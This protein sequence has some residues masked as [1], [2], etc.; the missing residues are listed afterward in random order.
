MLVRHSNRHL[1]KPMIYIL[2]DVDTKYLV[3]FVDH[4]AYLI[5][6]SFVKL[7]RTLL[8]LQNMFFDVLI[9]FQLH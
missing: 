5:V 9:C 8:L 1:C 6:T 3:V 7:Q 4:R 2:E